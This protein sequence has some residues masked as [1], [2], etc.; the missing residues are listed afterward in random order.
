MISGKKAKKY[1]IILIVRILNIDLKNNKCKPLL[2]WPGG[3]TSELS[4]IIPNIP[5]HERYFE[6]FF[7]GGSV[8]F[9]SINSKAYVNDIHEELI[10]FYKY[11]KKQ[12]Y[13]F[14][15]LLD[16]FIYEWNNNLYNRQNIYL[17]IR[18]RYNK[19]ERVNLQKV[20]DFFILR[21]YAYGGMFRLNSKGFFNVPFGHSYIK[22]DIQ[23]NQKV[24]Y[25]LHTDAVDDYFDR[26]TS[27][28]L[29]NSNWIL[30]EQ[31]IEPKSFNRVLKNGSLNITRIKLPEN[32]NARF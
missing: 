6:P 18:E 16:D 17:K 21:E 24:S 4:E 31:K 10:M 2:K 14:F 28:G 3:K 23:I 7:G 25:S 32:I 30:N 13:D 27:P 19:A 29:L 8:Y 5:K 11:I 12:E 22:K 1:V 20:V 15:L 26:R 9:Y